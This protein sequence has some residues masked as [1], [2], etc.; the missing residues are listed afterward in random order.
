[1]P[2]L[3]AVPKRPCFSNLYVPQVVQ[4]RHT[5]G[6]LLELM[7]VPVSAFAMFILLCKAFAWFGTS[8]DFLGKTSETQLFDIASLSVGTL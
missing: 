3:A 8:E 4:C 7:R 1:M 6:T 5:G 2:C